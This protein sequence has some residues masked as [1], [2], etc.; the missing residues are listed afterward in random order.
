MEPSQT[1]GRQSPFG[2][3]LGLPM[4]MASK[5]DGNIFIPMV[6]PDDVQNFIGTA[7]GGWIAAVLDEVFAELVECL[8][9]PATGGTEQLNVT[10][11]A[12]I[13]PKMYILIT[14]VCTQETARGASFSATV[15]CGKTLVVQSSMRWGFRENYLRAHDAQLLPVG[16]S[17]LRDGT[18][19]TIIHVYR[20]TDPAYLFISTGYGRTASCPYVVRNEK[21][22]EEYSITAQEAE[23]CRAS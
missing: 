22:G 15:Q 13:R 9:G 16:T 14:A 4:A 6:V 1:P 5:V 7:H 19:H 21:T 20:R 2:Q 3:R 18:P 23:A 17:L 11:L 12:P 10:F 8:Y